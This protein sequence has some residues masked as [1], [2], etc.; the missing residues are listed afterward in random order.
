MKLK[1]ISDTPVVEIFPQVGEV[2]IM[3][4]KIKDVPDDIAEAWLNPNRWCLG[5]PRVIKVEDRTQEVPPEVAPSPVPNIPTPP[6]P[7]E[8][9]GLPRIKRGEYK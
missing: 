6:E 3:P 8:E 7:Q 5:T 9:E 4:G 2:K 1:N